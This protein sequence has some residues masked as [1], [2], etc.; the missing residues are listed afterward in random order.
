MLTKRLPRAERKTPPMVARAC[1]ISTPNSPS[2]KKRSREEDRNL[3]KELQRAES[4]SKS[5]SPSWKKRSRDWE[6]ADRKLAKELQRAE[7]KEARVSRSSSADREL[8]QKLQRMED[9]A[10]RKASPTK[11]RSLMA[12]SSDGKAVLAVQEIITLVKTSKQQFIDNNPALLRY[13][14]ET[15]TI[16]DMVLMAKNMLEKQ[17]EFIDEQRPGHIGMSRWWSGHYLSRFSVRSTFLACSRLSYRDKLK[18]SDIITLIK[19]TSSI[20]GHMGYLPAPNTNRTMFKQPP[21]EGA[22]ENSV[23]LICS[24]SLFDS[25]F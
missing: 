13:S 5:N 2:W 4:I 22:F 15:V 14:V 6:T 11:E 17:K 23:R 12:K 10:T 3:A 24:S 8:A 21:K 16:D 18:T 20:F 1:K 9:E 19:E 25:F 7:R